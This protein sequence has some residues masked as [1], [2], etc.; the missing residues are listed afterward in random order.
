MRQLVGTEPRCRREC[1]VREEPVSVGSDE[2]DALLHRVEDQALHVVPSFGGSLCRPKLIGRLVDAALC[3]IELSAGRRAHD[4]ARNQRPGGESEEDEQHLVHLGELR[5][6]SAC[7][8]SVPRP[9]RMHSPSGAFIAVS[10][11]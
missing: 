3:T 6:R 10:R 11:A 2:E 8:S 5:P 1:G 7:S 4:E 9:F